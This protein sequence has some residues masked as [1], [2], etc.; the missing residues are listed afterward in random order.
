MARPK[1]RLAARALIG[2][3][4]QVKAKLESLAAET[5]VQEFAILSPCHDPA[6]RRRSY[7]L[8]AQA[9]DLGAEIM[10]A[11]ASSTSI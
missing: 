3:P 2:A 11:Q 1:P 10:P 5:G 9:F 7:E 6:A 4:E 8:L